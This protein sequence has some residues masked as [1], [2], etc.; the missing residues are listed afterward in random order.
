VCL[1]EHI[2]P[3]T[4][5]TNTTNANVHIVDLNARDSKELGPQIEK[6]NTS[7]NI[8]PDDITP[9]K[10]TS[11]N[12]NPDNITPDSR[13]SQDITPRRNGSK[14][15]KASKASRNQQTL[16]SALST[17]HNLN[18]SSARVQLGAN[19]GMLKRG[20][21]LKHLRLRVDWHDWP[22]SGH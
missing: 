20:R 19:S 11:D 9:D 5:G 2:V 7:D 4:G 1:E 17:T 13:S 21:K 15:S 12:I 22:R 18:D 14:A 3:N 6:R 10:S 8:N 16:N